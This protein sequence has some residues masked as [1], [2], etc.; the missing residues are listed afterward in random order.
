[1]SNIKKEHGV[2]PRVLQ[3]YNSSS[4]TPEFKTKLGNAMVMSLNRKLMYEHNTS[5]CG[6]NYCASNWNVTLKVFRQ[7]C[8]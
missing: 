5:Q 8:L 1:M 7:A 3:G 6:I 4:P 2:H